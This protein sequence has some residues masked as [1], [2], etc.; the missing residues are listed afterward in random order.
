MIGSVWSKWDLHIHSPLTNIN[1]QYKETDLD[2]FAKEVIANDIELLGITNY[3]YLSEDELEKLRD[4]FRELDYPITILGNVEFRISQ[5]NK[6]GEWI[7]IHV[8]FSESISTKK[9][10]SAL[11]KIK[12][13]NTTDEGKSIWCCKSSIIE[14]KIKL[15]DA[16][17]DFASLIKGLDE[18]FTLGKDY[19]VAICPNG[20]G[21]FQPERNEG[22]SVAVAKEID[23]LGHIVLGRERDRDFFLWGERFENAPLKPVFVCSD[24]HDYQKIGTKY[25]WVKAKPNFQGLRQT[26]FEPAE[27]VQQNDSFVEKELIK[28]YFSKINISGNI[29]SEGGLKFKKQSIPLNKNMVSIIGGRGTG[30]SIFLD[31]IKVKLIRDI[32]LKKIKKLDCS[33]ISVSL[34]KGF[35]E[36]AELFFNEESES[37]YSYLHVSQGDIMNATV[38][39]V[40]LSDEIKEMLGLKSQSFDPITTQAIAENLSR[41]RDFVDFWQEKDFNNNSINTHQYQNSIIET[42]QKLIDT[43]TNPKNKQLIDLYQKNTEKLNKLQILHEKT[44]GLISYFKRSFEEINSRVNEYNSLEGLVNKSPTINIDFFVPPLMTNIDNFDE[45][46]KACFEENKKIRDEFHN[47]GINQDVSSLLQK[48]AEYQRNIDNAKK[49]LASISSKTESYHGYVAERSKLTLDYET[50]LDEEETKINDSFKRLKHDN[51]DWNL[52]QNKIVQ[53]ILSEIDIKGQISFDTDK[54]YTGLEACINRGKFRNTSEKT[55]RERLIE[56]FNIRNNNDFFSLIRGDNL[57][58]I[59]G[60]DT[61]VNIEDL[62]WRQEFF[63]QGGRYDLMHYLF[64]PHKIKEYLN[65]NAVF[66]Y[67][68]RTIDKLSVGQRGTFYVSLKLATDPFGSPFV[69][70]Q[71]EDDLDNDFIMRQLVPLFRAIKKYRQVIIVTHNA[72][73]VINS[74]SEQVIV[75]S[76]DGEIIEYNSGAIEDGNIK[77][78]TGIRHYICSILE[79]GHIAF[80]NREKKYGIL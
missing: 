13:S 15:H 63:N 45:S 74:D 38:D 49:E 43:L 46:I 60:E 25:T 56:T 61:K 79:G 66:T 8:I 69:F 5:P 26:L 3:W 27:R 28:P 48:I 50:F 22:R 37:P 47:Q 36:E 72:N 6:E 23:K 14:S 32:S 21:G 55:T 19:L 12:I 33:E 11:E 42:N 76:N 80:S 40:R 78:Q 39:P 71:P 59:E 31:A 64:S 68:G 41:Y 7:N 65:V 51:P 30:K 62:F 18:S 2:N 1:N 70:D 73:L 24:A 4:K 44:R 53:S 58:N 52:E 20:Y 54:F 67:R 9:I 17:I 34:N 77:S 57:I 29:F 10:N 16:F 35:G 75:A